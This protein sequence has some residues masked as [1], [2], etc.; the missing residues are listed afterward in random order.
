MSTELTEVTAMSMQRRAC[1][2]FHQRKNIVR[3]IPP[4][5]KRKHKRLEV[6]M[7]SDTHDY[8]FMS[9]RWETVI[10]RVHAEVRHKQKFRVTR[11]SSHRWAGMKAVRWWEVVVV[12]KGQKICDPPLCWMTCLLLLRLHCQPNNTPTTFNTNF[13]LLWWLS[14]PDMTTRQL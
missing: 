13:C 9:S 5:P 10:L 2:V 8:I 11:S 1:K 12:H 6:A 4:L 3:T 14:S 7:L